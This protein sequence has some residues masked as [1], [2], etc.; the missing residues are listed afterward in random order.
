MDAVCARPSRSSISIRPATVF[1]GLFRLSRPMRDSNQWLRRHGSAGCR[2]LTPLT[3]LTR[4][5]LAPTSIAPL[6]RRA[7]TL[8][9]PGPAPCVW[10]CAA[11]LRSGQNSARAAGVRGRQPRLRCGAADRRARKAAARRAGFTPRGPAQGRPWRTADGWG[12]PRGPQGFT[13]AQNCC[14]IPRRSRAGAWAWSSRLRGPIQR[15]PR[16]PAIN[17]GHR[18]GFHPGDRAAWRHFRSRNL[19]HLRLEWRRP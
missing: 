13:R 19:P 3:P 9:R 15:D 2:S 16:E 14:G 18:G 12:G 10:R 6:G 17:D 8:A 1:G 5:P 11:V 7:T 4:M